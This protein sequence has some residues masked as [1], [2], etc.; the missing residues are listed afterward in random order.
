MQRSGY[1]V[2]LCCI[3]GACQ[4]DVPAG[5]AGY[6]IIIDDQVCGDQG[7]AG[8]ICGQAICFYVLQ[9]DV[10]GY[11]IQGQFFA[12]RLSSPISE[13]TPSTMIS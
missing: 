4:G 7:P 9:G 11:I 5:G 13:E 3:Y 8:G 2:V 12:F 1:T 10:A 6:G